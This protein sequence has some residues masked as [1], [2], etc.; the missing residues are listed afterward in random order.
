MVSYV[1]TSIPFAVGLGSIFAFDYPTVLPSVSG[2]SIL[3]LFATSVFF[4]LGNAVF[5]IENAFS[6]FDSL[7]F[8]Q[9]S[10]NFKCLLF[11]ISC[12]ALVGG[13][14]YLSLKKAFLF[15]F[16]SLLILSVAGLCLLLNA[17][18]F[19]LLYLAVELQGLC[20]Y[21]LVALHSYS[22][23][24]IEAGLKYFVVG[25]L[26]SCLLLFGFSLLYFGSGTLSF[27]ALCLLDQRFG[28]NFVTL[29]LAFVALA[30][31]I[32]LGAVP[33]HV[34]VCD[35]YEGTVSSITAFFATAPK[36]VL[37][38]VVLKLFYG[39][40]L[41]QSDLCY[42]IVFFCGF[43]SIALA[44]FSA[45]YQKRV[46]RLLAYSAISHIGFVFL[47]LCC[48]TIFSIQI[49]TVY[50]ALYVFMSLG[51]FMVFMVVNSRQ[52]SYAKYLVNWSS[53]S[54]VNLVTSFLFS[55]FLLSA[56]GVPPLAGFF[57]KFG[58]LYGLVDQ[59]FGFAALVVV[60][61]S[62]IS[63][64]YYIRLIKLM[65]F[66]KNAASRLWFVSDKRNL[67]FVCVFLTFI[68]LFIL[69]RPNAV[70]LVAALNSLGLI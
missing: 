19:L 4:I 29:G 58:I 43:L 12:L 57:T 56:A 8:D 24:S 66:S 60:L 61:V 40:F 70:L 28:L 34:W 20:F 14:N 9:F 32:K 47:G 13:R 39:L 25:A 41:S 68:T 2:I 64:F 51:S 46:K 42:L 6:F 26:A 45:L 69:V 7:A 48:K 50:I 63:S 10:V 27:D 38:A 18:N 30:F 33:F 31:S 16:D 67:E 44:T 37:V 22:E 21:A 55:L 11:V 52:S 59:Q 53:L 65:F 62:C 1:L 49:C 5:Q 35:V 17:N 15:E 54:N 3:V 36:L 23:F